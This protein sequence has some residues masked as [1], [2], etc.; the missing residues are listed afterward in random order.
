MTNQAPELVLDIQALQ[1]LRSAEMHL[2]S[3]VCIETCGMHTCYFTDLGLD[4][5]AVSR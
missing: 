4:H 3:R 5:D 2:E 1:L